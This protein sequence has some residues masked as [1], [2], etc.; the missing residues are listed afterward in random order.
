LKQN[1]RKPPE[2]AEQKIE[3]ENESIAKMIDEGT[4]AIVEQNKN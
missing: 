4:N 3:K 2:S 1:G